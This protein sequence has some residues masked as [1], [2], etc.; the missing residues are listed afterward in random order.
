MTDGNN[1]NS[2]Y[3][4]NINGDN[5]T[6]I[7]TFPGNTSDS[8]F[9]TNPFN[10]GLRNTPIGEPPLGWMDSVR[11]ARARR[12]ARQ[13]NDRNPPNSQNPPNPPSNQNLNSFI[14][15]LHD[16]LGTDNIFLEINARIDEDEHQGITLE[17]LS[18]LTE[19]R[20]YNSEADVQCAICLQD[21]QQQC[22]LRSIK[23]CGHAFHASCLE[24]WLFRRNTCPICRSSIEP[25]NDSNLE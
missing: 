25:E 21:C 11:Q 5:N 4:C 22:I 10:F 15:G 7:V 14:R 18:D 8:L 13:N 6:I 23:R 1:E 20:V 17:R 2:P 3:V 19:T 16:G 12:S 9:S 24:R